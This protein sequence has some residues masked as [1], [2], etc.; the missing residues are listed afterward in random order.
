MPGS[1]E[2]WLVHAA[3]YPAFSLITKLLRAVPAF[4]G[5][6]PFSPPLPV[7]SESI[8]CNCV[9]HGTRAAPFNHRRSFLRLARRN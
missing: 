7:Q 5:E 8:R 6:A 3:G 4:E 1:P 2:H 9:H